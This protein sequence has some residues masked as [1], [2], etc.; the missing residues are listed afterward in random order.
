MLK[1]LI[2]KQFN[3]LFSLYFRTG[4]KKSLSKAGQKTTI[5]LVAIIAMITMIAFFGMAELFGSQ[6]FNTP[7]C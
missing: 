6:L 4:R 2:K 1:T 3:E 5:I 7:N